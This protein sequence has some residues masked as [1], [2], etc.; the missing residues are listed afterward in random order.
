MI[1]RFYVE[2]LL[3]NVFIAVHSVTEFIGVATVKFG[4]R[5]INTDNGLIGLQMSVRG[6]SHLPPDGSDR[7]VLDIIINRL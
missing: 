7:L 5:H 2:L 6:A 4:S 1:S 3:R